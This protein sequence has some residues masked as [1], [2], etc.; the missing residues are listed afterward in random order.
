MEDIS[1]KIYLNSGQATAE[2]LASVLTALSDL[3]RAYGS[4]GLRFMPVPETE[5]T[6]EDRALK[7][8]GH[9]PFYFTLQDGKNLEDL[10]NRVLGQ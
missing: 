9:V 2:D 5:L 1:H 8:M 6:L 3:V 10:F 4:H 7:E